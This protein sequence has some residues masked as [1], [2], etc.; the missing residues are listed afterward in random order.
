MENRDRV[1]NRFEL[2]PL[3]HAMTEYRRGW[4]LSVTR[5][6]THLYSF[7]GTVVETPLTLP[8]ELH[9]ALRHAENHG[10]SDRGRAQGATG[11]RQELQRYCTMIQ[12][13]VLPAVDGSN[14]QLIL[15]ADDEVD[16][17][18]RAINRYPGLLDAGLPAHLPSGEFA[19]RA[20]ALLDDRWDRQLERWREQFGTRRSEGLATSGLD[21][22]ALAATAAAVDELYFAVDAD[23]SG[24]IDEQGE[25]HRGEGYNLVDEIAARVLLA[26]GTVRAVRSQDLLNGSPVAATL[27]FPLPA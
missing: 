19:D 11:D 24:T 9:D 18:Y 3:L 13:A 17:A 6:E 21:E 15:G 22:V 12:D 7:N 4:L 8:A 26:G 27:R 16:A 23:A 2:G 5:G 20:R 25:V 1:S 10:D 14:L